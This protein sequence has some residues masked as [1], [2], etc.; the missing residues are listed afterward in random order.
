MGQQSSYCNTLHGYE[1][2]P[3]RYE[4]SFVPFHSVQGQAGLGVWV[5]IWVSETEKGFEAQTG[6]SSVCKGGI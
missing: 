6:W 1:A 3:C 5:V 4:I 2:Y